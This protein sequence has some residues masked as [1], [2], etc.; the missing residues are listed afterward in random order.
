MG[1]SVFEKPVSLQQEPCAEFS[2]HNCF[3]AASAVC[4]THTDIDDY[5][6]GNVAEVNK[7]TN[8]NIQT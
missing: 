5:Y 3:S 2:L 8:Q 6:H 1:K 7:I 4:A